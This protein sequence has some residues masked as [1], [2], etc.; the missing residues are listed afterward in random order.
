MK[1][2]ATL[3]LGAMLVP[4]V[5]SAADVDGVLAARAWFFSASGQTNGTDLD[6][7]DFDA[8]KG[9]PE[10]R[11]E[12]ALNERHHLAASYLRIR[13]A[14]RGVTSGTVLGVV[15]FDDPIDLDVSLDDVRARYGYD[16][17]ESEWFELEPFLEVAYVRE[18]STLTELLLGQRTHQRQSIV[19]PLPGV[20]VASTDRYPVRI[21]ASAEGMAIGR[22][23][24]IDVQGGAETAIRFA[25]AGVGYRYVDATIDDGDREVADV[26]LKGVYVEG[27]IRF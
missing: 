6:T 16:V 10:F 20:A 12:L 14:E 7:L 2:L 19:F 9:Q 22:G 13:R 11:G 1:G 27:G 23:H 15:R 24:L 26:R 18:E 4:P 5:A 17:V 25:F 8:P 21:K 3:A